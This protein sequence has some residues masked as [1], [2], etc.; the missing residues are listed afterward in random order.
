MKNHVKDFF[1]RGLI[2]G[3]FGPI[4]TAIVLY[5]INL[6]GTVITLGVN[7][8]LLAIIST[9]ILAFVQAGA[10]VFNQIE[11]WP[12]TKSL[13]FHFLSIYIAY[14][15]CYLINSWIPFDINIILIFTA[16]FVVVYFAIWLIVYICTKCFSKKLNEKIK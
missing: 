9:Y 3:G 8:I 7:E 11:D 4:I 6:S 12:I 1:Q 15:G 13:F 16:I 2:F 5:C 14:I 10:T